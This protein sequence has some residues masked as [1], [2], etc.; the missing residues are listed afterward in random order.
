MKTI[1]AAVVLA[2]VFVAGCT[3]GKLN[4]PGCTTSTDESKGDVEQFYT[5]SESSVIVV[6]NGQSDSYESDTITKAAK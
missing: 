2:A 1:K 5:A 4:I 6:Q 3:D